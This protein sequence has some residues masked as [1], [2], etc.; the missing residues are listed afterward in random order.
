M[1]SDPPFQQKIVCLNGLRYE[2]VKWMWSCETYILFGNYYKVVRKK[3]WVI[4]LEQ[5]YS[6]SRSDQPV[7]SLVFQEKPVYQLTTHNAVVVRPQSESMILEHNAI[8][9]VLNEKPKLS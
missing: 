9:W 8:V 1:L 4:S 7:C 6:P 5:R 2:L 3:A